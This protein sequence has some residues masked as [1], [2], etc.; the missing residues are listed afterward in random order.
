M[1][2]IVVKL[3][4][5]L[6]NQ[7]FQY[8]FARALSDRKKVGFSLDITPFSTYYTADPYGLSKFNIKENIAKDSDLLGFIWL[9]KHNSFFTFIY[10]RLRLKKII[11]FWYY[12][13]KSF[14]YDPETFTSK[15]S[16]YEG[17]WQ[18]E[19]YF[20]N[21]EGDIRKEI[22]LKAPLSPHSKDILKKIEE[23]T[24]ISI[25]VRRYA[26]ENITPWHGFCSEEY[27]LSA[28]KKILT[29]SHNPHFFIFSD[30][31]SWVLEN[32]VPKLKSLNI[33]FTLV[34]ND[35]DKNA[36]D[37]ILMSKCKHHII[38][39]SSFSWWGAWLNPSKEKIVIAPQKWFAHAP[40]NDTTDLIPKEWFKM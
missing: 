18:T 20:K 28:I 37:L 19:K 36:E 40:K 31:Y 27:Y 5:G 30:N 3:N 23:T 38:A 10:H 16:Y 32:F 29:S 9:R 14:R 8:A 11:K 21:I 2:K 35:N 17:F 22:T 33:Q 26:S 6:C 4:G 39:N 15:A 7:I 25:H 24:A 1:K 34:N 12:Q 13:E